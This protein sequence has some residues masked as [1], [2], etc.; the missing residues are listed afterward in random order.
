LTLSVDGQPVASDTLPATPPMFS[1]DETFDVGLDTGSPAGK[2]PAGVAPGYAF[3]DGT[4][5]QVTI[6]LR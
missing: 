2:Y 4:I 3:T 1:I 6:E 5:D